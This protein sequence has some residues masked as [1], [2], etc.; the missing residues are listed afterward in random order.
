MQILWPWEV[1][2]ALALWYCGYQLWLLAP[3]FASPTLL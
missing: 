3:T 1:Y 2:A